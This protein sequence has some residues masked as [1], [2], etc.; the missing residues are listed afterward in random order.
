MNRRPP[1]STRTDT[2]FPYTTLFRS[3]FVKKPWEDS[4]RIAS[5]FTTVRKTIGNHHDRHAAPAGSDPEWHSVSHVARRSAQASRPDYV[6]R[7]HWPGRCLE[8]NARSRDIFP[9]VPASLAFPLWLA[10][11]TCGL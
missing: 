11:S 5:S 10:H 1:R 2:L 8:S 6:G 4:A 7:C 9:F 3:K